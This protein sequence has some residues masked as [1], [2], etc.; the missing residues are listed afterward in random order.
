[1]REFQRGLSA[2]LDDD[3]V[4]FFALVDVENIF[5]RE[6][7][8]IEFVAG[9]VIGGDG[10][11]VAVDHDGLVARIAQGEGG[12]DTAVVELDTLSDTV[13]TAAENHDF[14]LL[15]CVR[16]ALV[17]FAVSRIVV[18][19]VR[20][21]FGGAGIDKSVNRHDADLLAGLVD[22]LFCG[23]KEECNLPVGVSHFL[24]LPEERLVLFKLFER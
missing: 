22:F 15:L 12:V 13:R 7:L 3:A 10:F 2:E 9:V 8:E 16:A 5:K 6:R 1:M 23:V 17:D 20:F 11:G 18:R 4:A 19:C 24:D 21:E 14:F